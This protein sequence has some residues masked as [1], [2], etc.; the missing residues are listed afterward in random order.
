[1]H[2]P[3]AAIALSLAA[4]ALVAGGALAVS[5]AEGAAPPE[6]TGNA[7]TGWPEHNYDLSN[8]RATTQRRRACSSKRHS[9]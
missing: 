3:L 5:G 9:K 8:S 2:R 4:A 1:M 7:A 6:V